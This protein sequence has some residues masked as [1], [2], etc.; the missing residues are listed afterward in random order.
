M[1][2]KLD[3]DHLLK[4]AKNPTHW[5]HANGSAV[6]IAKFDCDEI[7]RLITRLKEAEKVIE[8]YANKENWNGDFDEFDRRMR[9][10][11]TVKDESNTGL[12]EYS[13]GKRARE[14]VEKFK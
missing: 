7:V 13:G 12:R 14:Y 5:L 11:I 9:N 4:L 8:F 10:G 2:H 1:T 6:E 3:L